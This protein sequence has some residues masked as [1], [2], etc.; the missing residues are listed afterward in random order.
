MIYDLLP[1]LLLSFFGW[2]LVAIRA[3][4]HIQFNNR[5]KL[6]R[7]Q[8]LRNLDVLVNGLGLGLG[9]RQSHTR[10]EGRGNVLYDRSCES[11][12][13]GEIASQ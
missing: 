3:H 7:F 8:R 5:A 10:Y 9:T 1:F 2:S 4:V 6:S 12:W 13:D 11:S